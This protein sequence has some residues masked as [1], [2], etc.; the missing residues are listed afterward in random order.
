MG[1]NNDG[2]PLCVCSQVRPPPTKGRIG[3]DGSFGAE[4]HKRKALD[5]IPISNEF[6]SFVSKKVL[7]LYPGNIIGKDENLF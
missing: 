5:F 2:A 3:T 6:K 7:S 4:R 1:R